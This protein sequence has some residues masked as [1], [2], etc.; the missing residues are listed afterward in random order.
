MTGAVQLRLGGLPLDPRE[1]ARL[2]ILE[3]AA[4]YT[5]LDLDAQQREAAEEAVRRLRRG[6]YLRASR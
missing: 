3:R 6:D 1:L 5:Q 4:L 2:S